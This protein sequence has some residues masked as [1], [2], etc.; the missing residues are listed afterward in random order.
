MG[1]FPETLIDPVFW[2]LFSFCLLQ[3]Q[4]VV[5]LKKSLVAGLRILMTA[6]RKDDGVFLSGKTL[7]LFV[8][9]LVNNGRDNV[10]YGLLQK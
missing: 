7:T 6:L 3:K 8:H 9:L 10:C 4:L 2:V 5:M 1:S